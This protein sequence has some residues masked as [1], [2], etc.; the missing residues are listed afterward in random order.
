MAEGSV[1]QPTETIPYELPVK[2]ISLE[3]SPGSD[4][5]EGWTPWA[6]DDNDF[7]PPTFGPIEF[8]GRMVQGIFAEHRYDAALFQQ[9]EAIPGL[10]ATFVMSFAVNPSHDIDLVRPQGMVVGVGI[11]PVGG[12]DPRSN[13]VQWALRDLKYGEIVQSSVTADVQG[14]RLTVFVRSIA[15]IPGSSTAAAS[16]RADLCPLC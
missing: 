16:G 12:T 4:I 11:D 6:A 2:N 3:I 7:A 1:L 10:T 8:E 15:F 9:V 13:D 14:D 5:A